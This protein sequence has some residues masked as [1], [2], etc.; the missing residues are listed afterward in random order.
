[1]FARGRGGTTSASSTFLTKCL[2][3]RAAD[4]TVTAMLHCSHSKRPRTDYTVLHLKVKE[5][6]RSKHDPLVSNKANAMSR[7]K[8]PDMLSIMPVKSIQQTPFLAF[9]YGP[10]RGQGHSECRHSRGQGHRECRPSRSAD[11][12]SN[13]TRIVHKITNSSNRIVQKIRLLTLGIR[14]VHEITS[15]QVIQGIRFAP[16]SP[17]PRAF[18]LSIRSPASIR[19]NRHRSNKI[20]HF[21]KSAMKWLQR[22]MPETNIFK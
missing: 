4:L 16:R 13:E 8:A 21:S 7:T 22:D 10:S 17:A 11:R 14:F 12:A 5:T 18:D 6:P 15:S 2:L 20:S 19:L 3:Q 9:I 1:M